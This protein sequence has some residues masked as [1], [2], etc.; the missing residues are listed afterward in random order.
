MNKPVDRNHQAE[1]AAAPSLPLAILWM[2]G[3]VLSFLLLAISGR[4]LSDTMTIY[5]VVFFRTWAGLAIVLLLVWRTGFH[6]VA[7]KRLPLHFLRNILH[8]GGI[9]LWF[10]G[11]SLLPLSMVFSLEFTTPIWTTLLAA[12]L[13]GQRLT[14]VRLLSVLFGFAGV[15]IILRPGLG[16]IDPAALFVL[17]AAVF[18]AVAFICNISLSKTE[19]PLTIIFYMGIIQAAIAAVP[20]AWFWVWPQWNDA[21]WIFLVGLC[22]V[23]SH[24]CFTRAMILADAVIVLP[25]DY[26]RLPLA[27]VIGAF[28][29]AETLDPILVLGAGV[30][31]AGNIINIRHEARRRRNH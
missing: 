16:I 25:V 11:I 28:I 12:P 14:P 5:Q 17:G 15:L 4:E 23:T 10:L 13:L 6:K 27:L 7:T 30:I 8:L 9:S 31:I 29:Y 3:A 21:I 1:A 18:Y 19:K 20:V 22:G 24:Y 2:S 26:L